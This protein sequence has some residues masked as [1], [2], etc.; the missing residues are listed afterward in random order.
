MQH[1]PVSY[2]LTVGALALMAPF[3]RVLQKTWGGTMRIGAFTAFLVAALPFQIS[4]MPMA[5]WA[6]VAGVAIA[7]A[8]ENGYVVRRWQMIAARR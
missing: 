1:L 7:T 3:Q 4:G 2:T 8:S 6:M 5:F